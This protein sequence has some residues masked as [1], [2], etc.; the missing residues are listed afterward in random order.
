MGHFSVE[1]CAPPGSTLSAN[2]QID[3]LKAFDAPVVCAFEATGNYHRPI[4]WRFM[5]A[6]FDTRLVSSMALART[7]EALHNGWDKNDPRDDQVILH[8]LRVGASQTYHDPMKTGMVIPPFLE[9]VW[10]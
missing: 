4:A 2:Q 5:E 8:M 6:G 7:R 10:K 1:T 9:G 3:I